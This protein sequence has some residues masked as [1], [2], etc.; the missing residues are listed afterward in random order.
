MAKDWAA[1]SQNGKQ[2]DREQRQ[3]I[4]PR[5]PIWVDDTLAHIAETGESTL[6]S[7]ARFRL[8]LIA[9]R[10]GG[11]LRADDE[12]LARWSGLSISKWLKMKSII[13]DSWI[14]DED[15][16]TYRI[17][18]I[19]EEIERLAD[20]SR[21]ARASVESRWKKREYDRNTNVIPSKYDRYTSPSPS[22]SPSPSLK[23]KSLVAD[24]TPPGGGIECPVASPSGNGKL[25]RGRANSLVVF[26]CRTLGR[27]SYDWAKDDRRRR[28]MA[29]ALKLFDQEV[30][31]A[32]ISTFAEN[33]QFAFHRERKYTGLCEY[34][35]KGP[36]KSVNA[37]VEEI[38]AV[39]GFDVQESGKA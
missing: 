5:L 31:E 34:I 37:R 11:R 3:R 17:H 2:D 29:E 14:F 32:A 36:H 6:V 23:N 16:Q 18:R 25:D 21:K 26:Y 35:L 9:C 27:K 38:L 19:E 12:S 4:A 8:W 33:S 7:G 24:A 28:V 13:V 15:T 30:L 1:N 39:G 20:Q 22:P 10:R